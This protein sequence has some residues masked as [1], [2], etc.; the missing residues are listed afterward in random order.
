VCLLRG[1]DCTFKRISGYNVQMVSSGTLC[2][3]WAQ[4]AAPR[5]CQYWA[6][7]GRC[8][9][10]AGAAGAAGLPAVPPRSPL[11]TNWGQSC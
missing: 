7:C 10:A 1:T 5:G 9:G 2:D 11:P 3:G 8:G 6:Q 4:S